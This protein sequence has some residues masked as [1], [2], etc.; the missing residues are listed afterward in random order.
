VIVALCAMALIAIWV[1][2]LPSEPI[3][4]NGI[5]AGY[6]A[7]KTSAADLDI[8][9]QENW[10]LPGAA[11]IAQLQNL[12]DAGDLALGSRLAGN[13]VSQDAETMKRLRQDRRALLPVQPETASAIRDTLIDLAD[14]ETIL[15]WTADCKAQSIPPLL[16]CGLSW[17]IF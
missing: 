7:G 4:A 8:S 15:L 1:G 5:V 2:G 10:G 11:A 13:H 9:A 14:Q 3:A 17:L 6:V 16:P 12:A